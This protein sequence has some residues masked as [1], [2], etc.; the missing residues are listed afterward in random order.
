MSQ[1]D[2]HPLPPRNAF[3]HNSAI[4]GAIIAPIA[5]AL[6]PRKVDIRFFV[7]AGAFSLATN[8]LAYEYTGQSIYGRFGSRMG[9]MFGTDLP[10]GAKRTQ[11]LLRE[12]RERQAAE[13]KSE[14]EKKGLAKVLNDTWM[15]G[16]SEDWREK[17][18]E[19][20]R[21]KFAE[22]KG[23]G[24]II[25]EQVAEVFSGS[26]KKKQDGEGSSTPPTEKK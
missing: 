7:L 4:A 17:R 21:K 14:E 16:E 26:D 13:K 25:M 23:F 10:E 1:E 5:M 15:G 22:G 12:Q 20:H 11:Q 9:S 6:P 3:I 2:A 8:Q 24:D 19:E 18:A